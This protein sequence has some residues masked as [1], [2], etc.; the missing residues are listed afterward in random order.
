MESLQFLAWIIVHI[1]VPIFAP[2]ALLPLLAIGQRFRS[3]AKEVV[4]NAVKNGQLLWAGIAMSAGACYEIGIYLEHASALGRP[5]AWIGFTLCIFFITFS[6]VLVMLGAIDGLD[7]APHAKVAEPTRIMVVSI[8]L[9][10]ASAV[11]FGFAHYLI[12]LT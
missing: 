11:L 4:Y 2:I 9:T 12:E 1:A 3:S 8:F 6:A 5:F 7:D 10:T